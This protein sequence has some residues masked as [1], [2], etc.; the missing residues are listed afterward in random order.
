M[1]RLHLI[2]LALTASRLEVETF[3]M[4]A[5]NAADVAFV[6]QVQRE[7]DA[8]MEHSW[9]LQGVRIAH[10]S[11]DFDVSRVQMFLARSPGYIQ[12]LIQIASGKPDA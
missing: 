1:K 2:W 11:R 7:L 9:D 6:E 8:A 12:R 3:L 10:S 5:Q 4:K